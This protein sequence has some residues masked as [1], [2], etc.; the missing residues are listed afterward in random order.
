MSLLINYNYKNLTIK[1][2]LF[3]NLRDN[4]FF[5]HSS[6]TDFHIKLHSQSIIIKQH[7]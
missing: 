4:Y 2:L 6:Y 3:K 1:N 5:L 7:E